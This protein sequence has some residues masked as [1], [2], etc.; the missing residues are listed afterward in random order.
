MDQTLP[1]FFGNFSIP[2]GI[3]WVYANKCGSTF[4]ENFFN[5]KGYKQL[6]IR[7]E[8]S[9]EL[10]DD[11][12]IK[13][14]YFIYRDPVDRFMAWYNVFVYRDKVDA[15]NLKY[16]LTNDKLYS[17]AFLKL[18]F[19]KHPDLISSAYNFLSSY[20]DYEL[21]DLLQYDTHTVPLIN[22][23]KYTKGDPKK[24]RIVNIT[25]LSHVIHDKF[26]EWHTGS[27]NKN[28]I[29]SRDN[30]VLLQKIVEILQP[31]YSGDFEILYPETLKNNST[32]K[33]E[34]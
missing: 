23:F 21:Y 32:D 7:D 18:S 10:I 28:A 26:F 30:I 22:Y 25:S 19:N 9:N 14:R 29:L 17:E 31:L 5:K 15:S 34:E 6:A 8:S 33:Q 16:N 27:F 12:S 1:S 3:L 4:L 24:Y 2:R 20:K 11:P 13:E